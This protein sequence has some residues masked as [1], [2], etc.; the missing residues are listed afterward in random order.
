[1]NKDLLKSLAGTE[2]M[3]WDFSET[4]VDNQ[5]AVLF[6]LENVYFSPQRNDDY[7]FMAFEELEHTWQRGKLLYDRSLS[8]ME[9]Y[10][11]IGAKSGQDY[12]TLPHGDMHIQDDDFEMNLKTPM[13]DYR[14]WPRGKMSGFYCGNL[15]ANGYW[16]MLGIYVDIYYFMR[17]NPTAVAMD[18]SV[19]MRT[20]IPER[21]NRLRTQAGRDAEFDRVYGCTAIRNKFINQPQ[22]PRWNNGR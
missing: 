16:A 21:Y 12:I 14:S 13:T 7:G 11:N 3:R 22:P 15:V 17:A 6:R 2:L 9:P 19:V 5:P 10:E 18:A 20:I 1:M 4:T 8:Y